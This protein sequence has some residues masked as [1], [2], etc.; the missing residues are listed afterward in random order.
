MS[1]DE[2]TTGLEKIVPETEVVELNGHKIDV[3][4]VENE[5]TLRAAMESEKRGQDNVDFFIDL[6]AKSLNQ[7]EGF[8]NITGQDLK[9][10]KG[11]ILPLIMAVQKVNGL[12]DFLDEEELQGM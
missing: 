3:N 1:E 5:K 7:N 11:N 8:E 2:Q 9:E 6:A 10:S 12:G 4:P